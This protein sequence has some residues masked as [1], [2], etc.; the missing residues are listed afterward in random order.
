MRIVGVFSTCMVFVLVTVSLCSGAETREGS[1]RFGDWDIRLGLS[2]EFLAQNFDADDMPA[3]RMPD[4]L[5]NQRK[6]SRMA[7]YYAALKTE[8]VTDNPLAHGA[9]Y[10]D[11]TLEAR[12][13]GI[14]LFC[15]LI[16]EHRGASYGTYAMHDIAVLPKYF[17]AMDTSF[18]VGGRLF[19]AG[20]EA[21]NF[22][23]CL[24]YEGLTIY[25]ID[26]QGYQIYLKWKHLKLKLH[27][28]G[29]ME[30]G[31][32]LNIN[33]QRDYIVS[34]EDLAVFDQMIINARAGYFDYCKSDEYELGLPGNG[35]NV[36]VGFQWKETVRLYSQV[37]IRRINDSSHS[38]I[39][40]CACL[41]GCTAGGGLKKFDL[42][43]TAEYRYYGR[44]FNRDLKY[45]GD[46]F[47]YR[48]Y[49]GYSGCFSWNTAGRYL[50]P[51]GLFHRPFSQWAVYTD[52]QGRDVQSYI[53]RTDASCRLPGNCLVICNL[54][55]N[56]M[57]VSNED[58][59]LYTFYDVGFGWAP[60][61]GASITLS[62]TNRAMNIDTHYPTLYMLQRGILMITFEGS[63]SF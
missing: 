28:I 51:L 55:F 14:T 20:L 17:V 50:Y 26:V 32:G 6:N 61:S 44:Y 10:A 25:N 38:G 7:Q 2:G 52:Y 60:V 34:L 58:S 46:C 8:K 36:S 47:L 22:D 12:K 39:K 62:H 4:Y 37:G 30:Y 27:H 16:A 11:M 57:D 40:R 13:S 5:G 19:H 35:M 43:L 41:I 63:L 42:D 3:I 31:I 56:Y 54:D 49:D 59:F 1:A 23:D 21:G 33:D 53:F 45:A 48:G 15:E 29:D 18:T 24:L 9:A